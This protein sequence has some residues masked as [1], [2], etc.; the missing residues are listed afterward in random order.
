M[1]IV[2]ARSRL[3]ADRI[4]AT[5][6]PPSG[7]F[8]SYPLTIPLLPFSLLSAFYRQFF[9]I[10]VIPS[11]STVFATDVNVS[12]IANSVSPQTRQHQFLLFPPPSLVLQTF[13]L[14]LVTSLGATFSY[15][16]VKQLLWCHEIPLRIRMFCCSFLPPDLHETRA[17]YSLIYITWDQV[18]H[19]TA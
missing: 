8:T 3:F 11:N 4:Y 6:T 12:V 1:L 13:F 2:L 14:R 18:E 19:K 16:S 10:V 17:R 7:F 15:F 9:S 5:E